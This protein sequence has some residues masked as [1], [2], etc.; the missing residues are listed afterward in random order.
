M[1]LASASSLSPSRN[2]FY[3][4][5]R[6]I[7][8]HCLP[9]RPLDEFQPNTNI[10]PILL[11]HVCS[12]WRAVALSSPFL[13]SHLHI[14]LPLIWDF[15][16]DSHEN[17]ELVLVRD[18]EALAC[19][20]EFMRW[21][22]TAPF[23]CFGL[24]RRSWDESSVDPTDNLQPEAEDFL[25]DSK[26]EWVRCIWRQQIL[27]AD[28]QAKCRYILRRSVGLLC[29]ERVA[30]GRY[31]YRLKICSYSHRTVPFNLNYPRKSV[32]PFLMKASKPS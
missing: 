18:F 28:V 11:C 16:D 7:F 2:V 6:E 26:P 20:I 32:S 31:Q 13:W 29:K 9:E 1:P 15:D 25:I 30:I 8:F 27:E 19:D 14:K 23:L 22:R 21:W 5:L 3:D 10:A 4:V 17:S 12:S 24:H